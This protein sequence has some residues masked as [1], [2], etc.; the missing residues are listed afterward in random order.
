MLLITLRALA[1][2]CHSQDSSLCFR[3]E[4]C[5]ILH[6][7]SQLDLSSHWNSQKPATNMKS[8]V[9]T[10]LWLTLLTA[11]WNSHIMS[12]AID[13][14]WNVWL[15]VKSFLDREWGCWPEKKK[16]TSSD[17]HLLSQ[18]L[19]F[20]RLSGT[21]YDCFLN[22]WPV[23]RRCHFKPDSVALWLVSSCCQRGRF[24]ARINNKKN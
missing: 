11:F 15:S 4:S 5:D 24:L 3:E 18:G 2:G 8:S 14:L 13:Q 12:Q 19:F 23:H 21:F 16:I 9:K 22:C 10:R 17:S 20:S 6:N 1:W 7:K